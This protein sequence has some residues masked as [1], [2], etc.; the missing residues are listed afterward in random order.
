MDD[1]FASM[2]FF[3][4]IFNMLFSTFSYALTV[5]PSAEVYIDYS[6][7]IDQ[8]KLK[9]YGIEFVNATSVNVTFGEDWQTFEYNDKN[10]R[11][12][13]VDGVLNNDYVVFQKRTWLGDKFNS[14]LF[15]TDVFVQLID[16]GITL[17]ILPN[18]TIVNHWDNSTQWLRMNL[19]SGVVGFFTTLAADYPNIT[20]AVYDT[21]TITLTV[22]ET[23]QTYAF[24]VREFIDWYT[25][26]LTGLTYSGLPW[27]FDWVFRGLFTLNFIVGVYAI[28]DLTKV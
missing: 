18:A 28:R 11:V 1:R 24:D 23:D 21:G 13:W 3:L 27:F 10:F 8:D 5:Y 19:D 2:F 25:S 14:W 20:K 4:L 12:R 7:S 6:I 16:A 9:E 26:M 17:D 22:G 15:Y